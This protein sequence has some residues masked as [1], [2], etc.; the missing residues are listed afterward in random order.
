[1]ARIDPVVLITAKLRDIQWRIDHEANVFIRL[2][3]KE[4][5]AVSAEESYDAAAGSGHLAIFRCFEHLF[6]EGPQE[7]LALH[8]V[9]VGAGGFGSCFDG[10]RDVLD[11]DDERKGQVF[12]RQFFGAAFRIITIA[13]IIALRRADTVYIGVTAM[14]IGKHKSVGRD[15]FA[16]AA[17]SKL[18]DCI[19]QRGA[20]FVVQL[21]QRHL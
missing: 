13:Q 9:S 10:F 8:R 21:I 19:A 18:A 17:A 12:D 1:M 3:D 11:C 6:A 15:H 16:R 2:F 7:A 14:V 4:I 5:E 20:V